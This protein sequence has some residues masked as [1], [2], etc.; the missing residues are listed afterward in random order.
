[1]IT[2]LIELRKPKL[3]L[4]L[5]ELGIFLGRFAFLIHL[6]FSTFDRMFGVVLTGSRRIRWVIDPVISELRDE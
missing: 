1:M 2:E 5:G 6:H 4:W 3:V